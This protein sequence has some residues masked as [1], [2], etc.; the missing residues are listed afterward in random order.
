MRALSS[1]ALSRPAMNRHWLGCAHLSARHCFFCCGTAGRH[2]MVHSG[3]NTEERMDADTG[4]ARAK[5]G[6]KALGTLR[7]AAGR[8]TSPLPCFT[9]GIGIPLKSFSPRSCCAFCCVPPSTSRLRGLLSGFSRLLAKIRCFT[10][11]VAWVG[12]HGDLRACGVVYSERG[13]ARSFRGGQLFCKSGIG[14]AIDRDRGFC[15]RTSIT[16]AALPTG[17]IAHLKTKANRSNRS[18]ATKTRS[19]RKANR[20]KIKTV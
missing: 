17:R 18:T 11:P 16:I 8:L 19:R 15:V 14:P 4:R 10:F 7:N 1:S 13:P 9:C 5:G 12:S 6:K 3:G 20:Q 2:K